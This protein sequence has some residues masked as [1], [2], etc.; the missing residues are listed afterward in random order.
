MVDQCEIHYTDVDTNLKSFT[1]IW[2]SSDTLFSPQYTTEN[3]AIQNK[4][5]KTS[6]DTIVNQCLEQCSIIDT[7]VIGSSPLLTRVTK[8]SVPPGL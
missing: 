2:L 3:A 1:C 8:P 5:P 4:M 7:Q 6:T